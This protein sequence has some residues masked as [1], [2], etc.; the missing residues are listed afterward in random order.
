MV[1]ARL[2]QTG[3]GSTVVFAQWDKELQAGLQVSLRLRPV[4]TGLLAIL[5]NSFRIASRSL[6]N[7]RR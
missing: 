3:L 2:Q 1:A 6:R 5:A 7:H 4:E